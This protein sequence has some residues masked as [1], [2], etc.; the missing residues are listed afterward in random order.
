MVPREAWFSAVISKMMECSKGSES[1]WASDLVSNSLN[2][3]L[4]S[5]K[6]P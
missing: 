2:I 3:L 6:V 4:F 1:F 5:G